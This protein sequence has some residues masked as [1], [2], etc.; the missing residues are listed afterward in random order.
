MTTNEVLEKLERKRTLSMCQSKYI[1]VQRTAVNEELLRE[2]CNKL[3]IPIR[4][5]L[6]MLIIG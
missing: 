3:N 1:R 4:I 6:G 2:E 5:Q